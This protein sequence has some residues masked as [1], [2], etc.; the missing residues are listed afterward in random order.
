MTNTTTSLLVTQPCSTK[1]L[2]TLSQNPDAIPNVQT[3]YHA[4]VPASTSL[5]HKDGG[6]IYRIHGSH[7][8]SSF[9]PFHQLSSSSQNRRTASPKR[10]T[11]RSTGTTVQTHASIPDPGGNGSRPKKAIRRRKKNRQR[12]MIK[13]QGLS[14]PKEKDPASESGM[15]TEEDEPRCAHRRLQEEDSWHSRV[16]RISFYGEED[17]SRKCNEARQQ[18]TLRCL[19]CYTM[20]NEVNVGAQD[21]DCITV[22]G[23]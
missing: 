3:S 4:T 21:G 11:G 6:R 19:R 10:R 16:L 13:T 7:P 1:E 2:Q 8:R 15:T 14:S 18:E 17:L 20:Q 12:L 5:C 9:Q 22:S 23:I